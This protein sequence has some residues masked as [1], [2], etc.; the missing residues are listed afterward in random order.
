MPKEC[1]SNSP[2]HREHRRTFT[3]ENRG[4]KVEAADGRML[5]INREWNEEEKDEKNNDRK[6]RFHC[7]ER[8]RGKFLRRFRLPENAKTNEVKASMENGVGTVTI[9]KHEVKNLQRTLFRLK[10]IK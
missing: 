7:V 8:F 6:D 10:E 2:T 3:F 4:V 9:P 1:S 5:Q